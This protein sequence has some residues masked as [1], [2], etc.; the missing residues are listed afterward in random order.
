[1]S[2]LIHQLKNITNDINSRENLLMIEAKRIILPK[3]AI[4]PIMERLHAG[5]AG[6]DKAVKLAQ[7]L[8]FWQNMTNDN[9]SIVDNCSECQER[10]PKQQT[11]PRVTN[12]SSSAYGTPMAHVGLGLFD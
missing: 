4:K 9:K 12:P 10:S 8:Y 6:Q 11:N 1:M 3:S 5:H 2:H 7:Q